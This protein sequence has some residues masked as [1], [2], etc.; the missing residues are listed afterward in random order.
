MRKI[1]LASLLSAMIFSNTVVANS[2]QS[3]YATFKASRL[4]NAFPHTLSKDGGLIVEGKLTATDY[5]SVLF[6]LS[7]LQNN[8]REMQNRI[9]N[10]YIGYVLTSEF[11]FVKPDGAVI[12]TYDYKDGEFVPNN[13]IDIAA[14]SQY[15][16]AFYDA[17]KNNNKFN[18]TAYYQKTTKEKA[19]YHAY[20]TSKYVL[21]NMYKSGKF[22]DDAK[23]EKIDY[24][25]MANGLISFNVHWNLEKANKQQL[26]LTAKEIYD[27]M[28][29][30][31]NEQYK[32]FDFTGDGTKVKFD[33][34][35]FG[36]LL[37]GTKDLSSILAENG[38]GYE[39]LQLMKNTDQMVQNILS[40]KEVCKKEGLIREIEI[41]NGTAAGVK[42]KDE[43]N[44]GRLHTFLY[45]FTKW[46]ESP[47]T[48]LIG[49]Q[50]KNYKFIKDMVLYSVNNHMD[51]FAIIHDTRFS[52]PSVK[53][54]TKETPYL[55][56]FMIN[57]D[58]F[59]EN[60]KIHLSQQEAKEINNAIEKN[61]NF[62]MK[63]IFQSGKSM[64]EKSGF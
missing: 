4:Q 58:Y 24:K 25:T 21:D 41:I 60:H 19:A 18:A 17:Y 44:T 6:A 12:S 47:F 43:V 59:V 31:W 28:N 32:V 42:D 40:N 22:Y 35:D 16:V 37:W 38:Y 2:I 48:Q 39:A 45:A 52:D 63:N 15:S 61:Y 11:L 13:K 55:T 3:S 33:L 36:L 34:R 46:N 10:T 54:A 56:W 27:T 5:A 62:L 20:N 9:S 26:A 30:A 7:N 49:T 23:K 50:T 57:A 64:N 8:N 51:E 14:A 1:L 53:D 29:S